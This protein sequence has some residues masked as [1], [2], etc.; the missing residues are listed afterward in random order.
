MVLSHGGRI[1]SI[2]MPIDENLKKLAKESE[3]AK[4]VVKQIKRVLVAVIY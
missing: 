3:D 1:S 4:K 2:I